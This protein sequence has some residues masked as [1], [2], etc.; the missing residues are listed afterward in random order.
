MTVI[1][2]Q[3]SASQYGSQSSK[4]G[5]TR[6]QEHDQQLIFDRIDRLDAG[7]D[8][9]GHHPRQGNEADCHSACNIDP[10]IASSRMLPEN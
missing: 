4:A 7:E 10:R 6:D 2:E 1:G 8:L 9:A 3:A 5:A